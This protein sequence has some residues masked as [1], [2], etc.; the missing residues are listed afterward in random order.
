MSVFSLTRRVTAWTVINGSSV[1]LLRFAESF[2]KMT[3][4]LLTKITFG[5]LAYDYGISVR[6]IRDE[7]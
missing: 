6:T 5:R 1:L 4:L 2:E 3:I 7:D